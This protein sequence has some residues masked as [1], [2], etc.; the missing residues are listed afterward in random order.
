MTHV[1]KQTDK[2]SH[3]THNTSMD[4]ANKC[5][6]FLFVFKHKSTKSYVSWHETSEESA[7]TLLP[8]LQTSKHKHN[9]FSAEPVACVTN[10]TDVQQSLLFVS[11]IP[12]M[13]SR[14]SCSCHKHNRFLMQPVACVTNTT[15][16]HQSLLLVSQT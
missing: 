2:H 16:S 11:Q 14:P 15:D 7:Q 5:K 1:C 6:F 3:K 13:F 12:Q 8:V 10:T 9:R 4:Q